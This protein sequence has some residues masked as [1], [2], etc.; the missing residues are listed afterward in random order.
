[1]SFPSSDGIRALFPPRPVTHLSQDVKFAA[2]CMKDPYPSIRATIPL[3]FGAVKGN[4]ELT[5][6]LRR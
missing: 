3:T 2:K 6:F 4:T 5:V 1:M